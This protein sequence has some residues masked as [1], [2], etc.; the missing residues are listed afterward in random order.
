VYSFGQDADGSA[1]AQGHSH[2][3]DVQ[4]QGLDND[5]AAARLEEPFSVFS[6]AETSA[7]AFC[8]GLLLGLLAIVVVLLRWIAAGVGRRRECYLWHVLG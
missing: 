3:P 6:S 1:Q 5:V 7:A 8:V 4:L 2:F